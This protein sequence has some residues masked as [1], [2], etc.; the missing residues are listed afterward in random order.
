M[1]LGGGKS[2]TRKQQ[3]EFLFS[4]SDI[5]QQASERRHLNLFATTTAAAAAA[6]SSWIIN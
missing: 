4:T 1:T 2:F 3:I 6:A 5:Q